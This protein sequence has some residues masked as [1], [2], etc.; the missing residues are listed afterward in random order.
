MKGDDSFDS[1]LFSFSDNDSENCQTNERTSNV[2]RN[3]ENEI[4]NI[5]LIKSI[6]QILESILEDNKRLVNFSQIIKKQSKIVFN[7]KIVPS[8]SLEKYLI[9]IQ[10]YTNLERNSLIAG[11][12]YIDRFC[13]ISKIIFIYNNIHK[14]LFTSI[15][16]SI[17]FNEDQFYENKYYAEIAGINLNELNTLEY[18]YVNMIQFLL[19]IKTE[20]FKDYKKYLDES[21]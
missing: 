8:I 10:T 14:I 7:S 6:S 9:R 21:I 2:Q 18:N 5:D 15:L 20:T 16:L 12:I 1:E 3:E 17:K 11:L 4:K 19:Y 13:K